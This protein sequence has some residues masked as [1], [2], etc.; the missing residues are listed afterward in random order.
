MSFFLLV[1]AAFQCDCWRPHLIMLPSVLKIFRGTCDL[2]FSFYWFS[3]ESDISLENVQLW[4]LL[5]FILLI[6]L[7]KLFLFLNLP[8]QHQ[9]MSN[10]AI[11]LLKLIGVTLSNGIIR[12]SGIRGLCIALCAHHPESSTPLSPCIWPLL[13]F[14]ICLPSL[15]NH[16]TVSISSFSFI[17]HIWVKS[18]GS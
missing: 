10:P 1:I 16:H 14:T 2:K 12:V 3:Q 15:G 8:T 13:P 7:V 6:L 17:S 4:L 9:H 5:L 11:S 18:Y